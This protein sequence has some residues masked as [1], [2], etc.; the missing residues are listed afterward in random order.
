MGCITGTDLREYRE[1]QQRSIPSPT[2][3]EKRVHRSSCAWQTCFKAKRRY[4]QIKDPMR[5]C[6]PLCKRCSQLS[7]R[8]NIHFNLQGQLTSLQGQNGWP[9][10]KVGSSCARCGPWI[11][12]SLV[13]RP[14]DTEC[15]EP[16][17]LAGYEAS[18]CIGL[19][20][21]S[22]NNSNNNYIRYL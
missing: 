15:G 10:I 16:E 7:C 4:P 1:A 19:I 20:H 5:K 6:Q 11:I 13:P 21:L 12:G 9:Q 22:S 8:T 14:S 17:G 3:N 18:P 2:V